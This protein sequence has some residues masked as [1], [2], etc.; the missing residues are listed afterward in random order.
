MPEEQQ[1]G[2]GKV[3]INYKQNDYRGF[4][5]IVHDVHGLVLLR[6]LRKKDKPPHWQVPGGH[7]DEPEFI[8]AGKLFAWLA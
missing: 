7:V 3:L 4:I 2:S 6:C 1:E 5:F 8:T